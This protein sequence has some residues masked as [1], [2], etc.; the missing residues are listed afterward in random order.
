MLFTATWLVVIG[1]VGWLGIW[2]EFLL[3]WI[4]PLFTTTIAIG[5]CTELAEHYPLPQSENKRLLMT[6][7]RHGWW[8]ERFLF[9]RHD[10]NY[11]L[12]HHI[13]PTVPFHNLKKAHEVLLEDPAYRQWDEV[14]GGIFTRDHPGQETLMSYVKKYRSERSPQYLRKDGPSFAERFVNQRHQLQEA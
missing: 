12:V 9:G 1:T 8:L 14:W 11:H 10:D 3:F 5:W 13:F 6:R 7:N 4:V 2:L